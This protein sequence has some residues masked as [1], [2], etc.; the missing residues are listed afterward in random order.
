MDNDKV[1]KIL[2]EIRTHSPKINCLNYA[3]VKDNVLFATNLNCEIHILG[4]LSNGL[5]NIDNFLKTK[6][7]E[8]SFIDDVNV[9]NEDE[10]SSIP[11]KDDLIQEYATKLPNDIFQNKLTKFL[12]YTRSIKESYD[13]LNHIYFNHNAQEIVATNTYVLLKEKIDQKFDLSFSIPYYAAKIIDLL[14]NVNSISIYQHETMTNNYLLIQG[15]GY[16]FVTKLNSE[17]YPD[18]NSCIPVKENCIEVELSIECVN[19]MKAALNELLKYMNTKTFLV[20]FYGNKISVVNYETNNH[21]VVDVKEKIMPIEK[22]S[23]IGLNGK[24]FLQ[25]LKDLN[26]NKSINIY[27]SQ[28]N[29]GQ[30]WSE[31]GDVTNLI[32]PLRIFNR[33]F[34]DYENGK[35]EY[36]EKNC[37]IEPFYINISEKEIKSI[38]PKLDKSI[39]KLALKL[40]EKYGKEEVITYL[41]RWNM[42]NFLL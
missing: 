27:Y 20:R 1:I 37:E 18:Y 29:L 6:N 5:Y 28:T 17:Q 9:N 2:K 11:M 4:E 32:M 14:E 21:V 36:N 12:N 10:D 34:N 15:R 24:L 31:N 40:Q 41:K 23:V 30:I 38:K 26:I 16:S 39:E 8:T 22:Y 33:D 25:F 3:T 35:E 13:C 19:R 7:I 42:R